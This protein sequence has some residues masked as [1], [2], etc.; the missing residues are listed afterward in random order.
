[1]ASEKMTICD[2]HL[3]MIHFAIKNNII[4]QPMHPIIRT[5]NVADIPFEKKTI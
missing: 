3:Q 1:M 2:F 5:T 4:Q